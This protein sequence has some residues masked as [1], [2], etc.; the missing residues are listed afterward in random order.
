MAILYT[1]AILGTCLFLEPLLY[2]T[3][4][5]VIDKELVL[6][7]VNRTKL[8]EVLRKTVFFYWDSN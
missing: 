6:Y 8:V 1:E 7:Q 5:A 2:N 4:I 3:L